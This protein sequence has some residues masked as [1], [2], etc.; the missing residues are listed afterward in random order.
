[1]RK[2]Q[3]GGGKEKG[4]NKLPLLVAVPIQ[5]PGKPIFNMDTTADVSQCL[6]TWTPFFHKTR[7]R[8]NLKMTLL[9]WRKQ[10]LSPKS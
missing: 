9:F 5:L 7:R 3:G 8:A 10:T 1:M 6:G 4:Q 2:G